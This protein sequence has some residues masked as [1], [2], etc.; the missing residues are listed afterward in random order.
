[1]PC[2]KQYQIGYKDHNRAQMLTMLVI[3]DHNH[4]QMLTMLVIKVVTLS[5][6]LLISPGSVS[7][8]LRGGGYLCMNFV[9]NLLRFPAVQQCQKS[10]TIS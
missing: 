4:T 3:K 7:T 9:V 10:V 6:E 8:C 2:W 1:M 5:P